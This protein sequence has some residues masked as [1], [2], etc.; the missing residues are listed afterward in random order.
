MEME[1]KFMCVAGNF[2]L[3]YKSPEISG[4][5][6]RNKL[7]E[8]AVQCDIFMYIISCKSKE[9]TGEEEKWNVRN[10]IINYSSTGLKKS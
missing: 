7:D 6:S 8:D 1:I 3:L 5:S 4:D 10:Q 9:P 2:F